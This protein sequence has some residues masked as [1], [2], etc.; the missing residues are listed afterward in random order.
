MSPGPGAE[1]LAGVDAVDLSGETAVVTGAT[2]DI[3]RE[4]AL[5]LA[6]LGADLHLHGR[7]RET[8]RALVATV[9]A[10]GRQATF[11][12]S[13]FLDVDEIHALG[14]TLAANIDAVDVVVHNAGAH[15]SEG[16][17]TAAGIERTFQVNHVAPFLLTEHLRPVAADGRVVVVAS[18]AHRRGG[19]DDSVSAATRVQ[20]YDGFEQ[21]CTSKLANVL[22]TDALARRLE[23]GTVNACHPG[24]VPSSGLWRHSRIGIRLVMRVA[25]MLPQFLV[26][27]L[28]DTPTQAATTPVS[29]AAG[30]A[31]GVSG[32]YFVDGDATEPSENGRDDDLAE[33]LWAWSHTHRE[34]RI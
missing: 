24:F 9:E 31:G 19:L 17:R 8:G 34:E 6:R 5:A 2:G 23:R 10:L 4:I 15:F 25:S 20:D 27:R 33:A 16:A 29:L 12:R 21:Y 1:T 18:E 14:R 7:N 26:G 22:Y 3:G 13:D 11:H 32:E 28:V 30:G